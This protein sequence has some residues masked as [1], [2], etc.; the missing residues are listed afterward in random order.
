MPLLVLLAGWLVKM[1]RQCA[2]ARKTHQEEQVQRLFKRRGIRKQSRTIEF[3]ELSS[4]DM[5][6]MHN[7]ERE[8]EEEWKEFVVV[9]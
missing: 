2:K 8:V 4:Q 7:R 6:T 5:L 3:D 1:P 9:K